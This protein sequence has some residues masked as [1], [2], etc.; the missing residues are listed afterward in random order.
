[1]SQADC[2]EEDSAFVFLD[3]LFGAY[4]DCRVLAEVR[5]LGR[6]G[7]NGPREWYATERG[8]LR[9]A[10]RDCARWARRWNVHMGILPRLGRAGDKFAVTVARFLWADVDGGEEGQDGALRL[11]D[12]SEL[13]PT[14][15]VVGSGNGVH[16]Y[17]PIKEPVELPDGDARRRFESTLKRIVVRI[18]GRAPLSHADESS[19]EVARI[20][21]VPATLNYKTDPPKPVQILR[22]SVGAD[23][24]PLVKW[25]ATLP[26]LRA[27][28][29]P[30]ASRRKLTLDSE[31]RRYEGLVRWARTPY[32]EGKRHKDLVS[33]AA[34]LV[35]DLQLPLDVAGELLREKASVSGGARTISPQE[36][37]EMLRW[38]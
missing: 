34:W 22:C 31:L 10:S 28:A 17:W 35:R 1:M 9:E 15:L 7:A 12:A 30:P 24:W 32:P 11:L 16:A 18:G 25:E 23:A 13:P 29:P 6:G 26:A 2:H 4:G 37:E 21:R 14:T 19:A 5:C 38:A 3:L 8:G 36:V 33:A 20:L 27:P